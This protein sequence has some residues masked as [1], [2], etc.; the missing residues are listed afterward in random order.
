MGAKFGPQVPSMTWGK[1]LTCLRNLRVKWLSFSKKMVVFVSLPG[2]VL[3]PLGPGKFGGDG[4][5][6]LQALLTSSP[7]TL[8]KELTCL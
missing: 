5:Y 3:H 4:S 1:K 8:E 2:V 6:G 7:K